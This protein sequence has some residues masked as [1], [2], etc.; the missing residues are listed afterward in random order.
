L[1]VDKTWQFQSWNL[2]AYL[3][4]QNAYNHRNSEGVSYNY[5]YSQSRPQTG[6]P[7]LPIIGVRGEL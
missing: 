3:D 2:T 4:L 1:R 6:L 7:I 5:N